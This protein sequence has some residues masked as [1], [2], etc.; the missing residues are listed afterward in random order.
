MPELPEVETTLRGIAPH[1]IGQRVAAVRIHDHRLRWPIPASLPKTLT[2][3]TVTGLMRRSKYLLF[4]CEGDQGEGSDRAGTL[5]VHL[6]MTGSLRWH[7]KAGDLHSRR[8]HD[9]VDLQFS[10]GGT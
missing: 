7:S 9:H 10:G 6:G 1:A 3:R 5:L 8:I 2:G 4:R